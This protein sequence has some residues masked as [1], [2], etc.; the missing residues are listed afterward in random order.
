VLQVR[1][2]HGAAASPPHADDARASRRLR[3]QQ[4]AT[5]APLEF[6]F[7]RSTF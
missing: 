7:G 3:R 6:I 2:Y 5:F 1:L 4:L